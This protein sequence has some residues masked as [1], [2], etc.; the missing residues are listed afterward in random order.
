MHDLPLLKETETA[1]E[2]CKMD[3]DF[4]T[5]NNSL[6]TADAKSIFECYNP[7]AEI[8]ARLPDSSLNEPWSE[9]SGRG[10][11]LRKLAAKEL[12]RNRKRSP[13]K[14]SSDYAMGN[15]L[16]PPGLKETAR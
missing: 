14:L 8:C 13:G 12:R 16:T 10:S 2:T 1:D 11:V 9:A 6:V 4:F 5:G 3:E 15:C 7:P